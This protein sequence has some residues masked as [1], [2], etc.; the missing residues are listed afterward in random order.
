[1]TIGQLATAAGVNVET[2]RYYQRRGLMT[3]P[4]RPPGGQR[5]YP[6]D[7]LRQITFIRRAQDL[8]FTLDEIAALLA[9]AA[10]GDWRASRKAGQMKLDELEQRV[11]ELNR[12]R[13]ELGALVK[14]T[15]ARKGR[16]PCP[17]IA[18]LFGDDDNGR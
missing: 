12:M 13:R 17:F 15:E 6:D 2:I 7:A 10:D 16:E 5:R 4:Q 14:L 1:M 8:G 11:V 18:R 9:I 3:I